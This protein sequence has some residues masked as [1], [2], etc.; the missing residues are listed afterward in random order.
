MENKKQNNYFGIIFHFGI[1]SVP[2]Y[3]D[4]KST[5]YRTIKNG[6]EWYKKRLLVKEGDYMPVSGYIST[7]KYHNEHY[8][9]MGYNDFAKMF[10]PKANMDEWMKLCKTAGA[11]YVILTAKHHDGY[12]LF[13]TKTTELCSKIDF[14]QQFKNAAQKYGLTF[15]LY[16][17]WSE[18]NISFSKKYIDEIARPQIDE[19]IMYK[20][21]ILW[22]DGDWQIK[23]QS[24]IKFIQD[25]LFKIRKIIPNV[26][27]N[28]RLGE[29]YANENDLGHASY[30]NYEDRM[31]PDEKPKVAWEHIN[32]IGLSW[33]CNKAQVEEHY[34]SVDE[35]VELYIKVRKLDGKFLLNL[36]PDSNGDLDPIEVERLIG[37][38]KRIVTSNINSDVIMIK[39]IQKFIL[40]LDDDTKIAN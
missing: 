7:Q 14:V 33:G 40:F 26:S 19:L 13:P 34:K 36:G 15:G 12:C 18:F 38:G 23:S 16:Y 25:T 1:F 27:I 30:R 39:E 20:P 11:N 17:S 4:P 6:S 31:I 2:A 8:P 9:N 28:D 24:G 3:D 37:F 21:S 10:K 5:I 35:L 32:T 22:F 29:K